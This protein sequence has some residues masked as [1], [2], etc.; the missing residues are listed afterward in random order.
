MEPTDS[1]KGKTRREFAYAATTLPP[2][3][4]NLQGLLTLWREHWG[5][6]NRL[7]W[8]RVVAFGEYRP[9]MG[10][11]PAHPNTSTL[12]NLTIGVIRLAGETNIVDDIGRYAVPPS[13]PWP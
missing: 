3:G 2:A 7:H 9:Q 13:N 12:C 1:A 11:G 5:P 4:A 6:Q 10:T 8:V